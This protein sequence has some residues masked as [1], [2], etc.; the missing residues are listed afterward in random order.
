MN[1]ELVVKPKNDVIFKTLF[2]EFQ[3]RDDTPIFS[4]RTRNAR[5]YK[6]IGS[7]LKKLNEQFSF[8]NARTNINTL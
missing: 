8:Y 5:P 7:V 2:V 1:E 3:K 4:L 6:I